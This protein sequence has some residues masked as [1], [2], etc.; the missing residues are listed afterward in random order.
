MQVTVTSKFEQSINVLKVRLQQ[1]GIVPY[2]GQNYEGGAY[3]IIN[4]VSPNIFE[5][6]QK[7]AW[8]VELDAGGAPFTI[9]TK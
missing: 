1:Q 6:I 4:G 5:L 8:D 3:L 7:T 9:T 2:Y